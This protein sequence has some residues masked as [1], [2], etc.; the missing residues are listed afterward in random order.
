MKKSSGI[1]TATLILFLGF[2][3]VIV[4]IL[5]YYINPFKVV[6]G[7][8]DAQRKND[9]KQIQKILEAY[10]HDYAKYPEYDTN[11][12]TVKLQGSP[13]PWGSPFLPYASLLP[14]DPDP[15]YRYVYVS[16]PDGNNQTYRLYAVIEN[17]KD[18]ET[19]GAKGLD[20]PNVPAP[21]LCGSNNPC[22]YGITSK[23]TSP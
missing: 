8:F 16:D 22:N 13:V 1:T 3:L 19:C 7:K 10:Y 5:F 9:L 11:N 21:N 2:A 23:N 14:Q 17:K 6:A 4:G 18:P 20:C 12:Y 15:R